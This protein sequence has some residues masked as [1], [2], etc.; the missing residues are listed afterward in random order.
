[1]NNHPRIKAR[2]IG[3]IRHKE[4][5]F[6]HIASISASADGGIIVVPNFGEHKPTWNA[7][8]RIASPTF[9]LEAQTTEATE[10]PSGEQPKLHYHRSGFTSI[11]PPGQKRT[12]IDLPPVSQDAAR[13]VFSLTRI[14]PADVGSKP[15]REGD[16]YVVSHGGTPTIFAVS[17]ILIPRE[18]IPE[19]D[20]ELLYVKG[21]GMARGDVAESIM[22]L[23]GHNLATILVLR[24]NLGFE[25][26]DHIATATLAGF[27]TRGEEP[28]KSVY[29]HTSDGSPYVK[30]I[31]LEDYPHFP[32]DQSLRT[33]D[34]RIATRNA[35][36]GFLEY[37]DFI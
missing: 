9:G 10:Y 30:L 5:Y 11:Q 6:H 37:D 34:R 2:R 19:K 15:L 22:T 25:Q 8:T 4:G 20:A 26:M 17:G 1:M 16:Q 33:I 24:F 28:L 3:F 23:E 36:A 35:D 27:S 32:E 31:P 13:Q 14:H 7:R 18:Q 21:R 12:H 29:A